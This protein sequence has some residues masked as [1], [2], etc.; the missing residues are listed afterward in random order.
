VWR[1][2]ALN[3]LCVAAY[4]MGVSSERI[5]AWRNSNDGEADEQADP[6]PE[7]G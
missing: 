4:L 7:G 2:T 3:Q 5:A 6:L 1:T